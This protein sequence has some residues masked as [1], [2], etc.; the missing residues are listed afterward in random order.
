MYLDA[1]EQSGSLLLR[2]SA[3]KA[4]IAEVIWRMF[5]MYMDLND[6]TTFMAQMLPPTDS[7]VCNRQYRSE[8]FDVSLM[9]GLAT[10]PSRISSSSWLNGIRGIIQSLTGIKRTI[11]TAN[12]IA[13]MV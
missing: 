8:A 9:K 3:L 2:L 13:A 1:S 11:I 12:P 10:G 5:C 4:H 6:H 7:K